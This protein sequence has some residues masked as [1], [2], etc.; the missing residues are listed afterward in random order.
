M[1]G[2]KTRIESVLTDLRKAKNEKRDAE[3]DARRCGNSLIEES[4][5]DDAELIEEAILKI[6]EG[7]EL[8]YNVN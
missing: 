1:N 3:Y 7:L 4:M 2:I 5:A 6:E 8:L